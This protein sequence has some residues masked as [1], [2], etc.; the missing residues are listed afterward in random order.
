M[1]AIRAFTPEDIPAVVALRRRIFRFS[2][3]PSPE[4]MARSFDEIFFGNPWRDD[5]LPSFVYEVRGTIVGFLGVIPRAMVWEGR[6]LKAAV[7]TQFMVDPDHRGGPGVL[8]LGRLFAGAQDLTFSDAAT[9]AAHVVWER[10]GGETLLLYG[11]EWHRPLRPLRHAV[12]SL[13]P[14]TGWRAARLASRPLWNLVDA[15]AARAPNNPFHQRTPPGDA[16]EVDAGT[17]ATHLGDCLGSALHGDH[18]EAALSWLLDRLPRKKQYGRYQQIGVWDESGSF[19]GWFLYYLNERGTSLVAQLGSRP[20]KRDL[21]LDH[22]F[23]HAWRGGSLAVSGRLD[24]P[25]TRDLERKQCVFQLGKPW[26]LIHS[27]NRELMDS[28]H[29]GRAYLTRLDGEWWLNF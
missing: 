25:A 12:T 19:A 26:V 1:A 27:R 13:G 24:P 9:D 28:I 7:I 15:V 21:V 2:E 16:R 11:M 10:L 3:Q 5:S 6:P 22:L 18:D 14:A 17:I 23:H 20:G 29:A 4:G 8:M